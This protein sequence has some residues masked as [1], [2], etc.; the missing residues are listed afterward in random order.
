LMIAIQRVFRTEGSTMKSIKVPVSIGE[1]VDKV[2]ILRIKSRKIHDI[3][4]LANVHKELEA[5]VAVCATSGIELT[6]PLVD[7]L[8][9]INA[10]LWQI[11]DDIREKERQKSFDARFIELARAVYVTNDER[12]AVK[13]AINKEFGSEFSE[14]KSYESY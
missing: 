7:K 9:E 2:T 4:K 3:A 13:S 8:E 10:T 6:H 5:L 1:L 12:F 14:E 11:E